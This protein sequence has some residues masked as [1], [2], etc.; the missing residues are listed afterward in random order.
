MSIGFLEYIGFLPTFAAK[1][2][3]HAERS[4]TGFDSLEFFTSDNVGLTAVSKM[5]MT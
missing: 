4:L 3:L 2:E 1:Q 5:H